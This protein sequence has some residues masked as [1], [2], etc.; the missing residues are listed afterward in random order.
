MTKKSKSLGKKIMLGVLIGYVLVVIAVYLGVSFY[1]SNHFLK[2]TKI[3]GIDC[4]Y[5]TVQQVKDRIQEGIGEY[6]LQVVKQGGETETVTAHQIGLTYVDDNKVDELMEEQDQWKWITAFSKKSSFELAANTTYD[7]KN[8]DQILDQMECFQPENIISPQD[9]YLKETETAYEIVPEVMG[10]ELDREKVKAQMMEAIDSGK[11]QVDLVEGDC[12]RKP[13]V[14][15]DDAALVEECNVLNKYAQVNITYDF[16][17]RTEVVDLSVIRQWLVKGEDGTWGIDEEQ[18]TAFIKAMAL[19]YDTFG[20]AHEFTTHDGRKITLARGGDYG[21]VMKKEASKQE[22]LQYISEGFSGTI[23]PVYLYRGMC[24]DTNDIGD[25]YVEISIQEQRMWCF[26]DGQLIVD[27]PVVTGN[28]SKQY[29]TPA[30]SVWAIDAKKQNAVLTGEGYST[31]VQYWMPFNGN[32]G[33]HDADTWRSEYGGEIYKTSGSH[34]CVNTPTANAE[35][36]F[37]AVEIGT[38]V[39]VY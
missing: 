34:G 35:K 33:I 13:A 11:T 31:P 22:L 25:T 23:E 8:I 5:M 37:N 30:G 36:I 26:K 27:T 1:F 21:W 16:G 24:R 2:G 12:Y 39:I 6:S 19:K 32:V 7:P 29:D 10:N 38:P 9:A 18:V 20:L 17:D 14:T 3:N 28:V 4:T 15:K